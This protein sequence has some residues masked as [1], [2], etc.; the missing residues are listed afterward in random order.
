MVFYNLIFYYNLLFLLL[1]FI[2]NNI[3]NLIIYFLE[4]MKVG[5]THTAA[6]AL[7][8]IFTSGKHRNWTP[9]HE[10]VM[11]KLLDICFR[12][13]DDNMVKESITQYRNI[14]QNSVLLIVLLECSFING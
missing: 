14:C 1:Y 6:V 2:I 3:L 10:N 13:R 5:E 4:L 11:D 12:M 9:I 7:Y 8:S